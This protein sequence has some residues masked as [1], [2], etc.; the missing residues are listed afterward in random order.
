MFIS[1]LLSMPLPYLDPGSGSIL[2]Q[3]I[4]AAI[5]GAGILL[6]SQW[7]RVKGW[8]GGKRGNADDSD[9][10]KNGEGGSES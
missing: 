6:R 2:F 1:S 9:N 5:L 4:V 8:F 7:K 3:M 10:D